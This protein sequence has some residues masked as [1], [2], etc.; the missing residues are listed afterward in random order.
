LYLFSTTLSLVTGISGFIYFILQPKTADTFSSNIVLYEYPKT[1]SLAPFIPLVACLLVE[2]YYAIR[3]F[4]KSSKYH[5]KLSLSHPRIRLT[6]L[7]HLVAW[8]VV[9]GTILFYFIE[10]FP[11]FL[12]HYFIVCSIFTLGFGD[13]SPVTDVGKLLLIV[14]FCIAVTFFGLAIDAFTEV[15]RDSAESRIRR[16]FLKRLEQRQERIRK[17]LEIYT[18][19][20]QQRVA[21]PSPIS[22]PSP[23]TRIGNVMPWTAVN[24]INHND[25]EMSVLDSSQSI[26]REEAVSWLFICFTRYFLLMIWLCR[27]LKMILTR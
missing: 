10:Q 3:D 24:K 6:L 5:S 15:R 14:Y 20:Q 9:I 7:A 19:K 1:A 12:S 11:L 17:R 27:H 26:L 16:R 13:L 4:F 23:V 8:L 22:V 18:L 21:T 25:D 2:F